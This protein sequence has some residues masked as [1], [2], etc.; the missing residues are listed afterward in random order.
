MGGVATWLDR[1]FADFSERGYECVVALARGAERNDPDR[2]RSFHPELNTI[3][4]DSRGLDIEGRIRACHRIINRIKPQLVIPLGVLDANLAA[5]RA[6]A[7]GLDVRLIARA[8]GNLPPMLADL[9]DY[10]DGIDHVVCV[11]ALTRKFLIRHAGFAGDR[12]DHIPNGADL[13]RAPRVDRPPSSAIRLGFIGRLSQD[14]KRV[15]DM[16]AF[17][18]SLTALDVP[19]QLTIAGSGPHENELREALA[20]WSRCVTM[21]G[22]KTHREIYEQL[23]PRMDALMLFSST[24]TFGIVL[25]EAMM[26]GVVP[27]TSRYEGFHAEQLVIDETNG[28]SFPVGDAKSAATCIARLNRDASLLKTLSA[29]AVDYATRQYT[30]KNCFDRWHNVLNRVMARQPVSPPP[31]LLKTWRFSRG[32]LDRLGFPPAVN[33][34]LRRSRR[35]LF[36]GPRPTAGADEWPLFRRTHSAERLHAIAGACRRADV[37]GKASSINE[38]I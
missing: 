12:V 2:Y 35:A 15:L 8:Q 26:N 7:S 25:A 30:W 28:L 33:D 31:G 11:G 18:E 14:D 5:M 32:K 23:L 29:N 16:P 27:V 19:F 38:T 13:P 20:P 17:C 37:P 21:A 9:E 36:G 3:E 1:A 10:R 24:E 4:V 22:A 6:K 34:L